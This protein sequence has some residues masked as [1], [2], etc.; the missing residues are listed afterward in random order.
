M[1]CRSTRRSNA[2]TESSIS[3]S[4]S[5]TR[6]RMGKLSSTKSSRTRLWLAN[7]PSLPTHRANHLTN[8]YV[9]GRTSRSPPTTSKMI[10]HERA[11]ELA[12]GE[13]ARENS[14]T[15]SWAQTYCRHTRKQAVGGRR[16]SCPRMRRRVPAL[17]CAR[18]CTILKVILAETSSKKCGLERTTAIDDGPV[19]PDAGC[20][21][22]ELS[23]AGRHERKV[24]DDVVKARIREHRRR[25]QCSATEMVRDE[26]APGL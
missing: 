8:N 11:S 13:L 7:I 15:V 12:Y 23:G 25:G 14:L 26:C 3:S 4:S 10:A 1:R 18:G 16:G 22:R 19:R 5:A 2:S 6:S 21:D 17:A 24:D 20:I 9:A